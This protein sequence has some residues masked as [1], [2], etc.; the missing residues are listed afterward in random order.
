MPGPSSSSSGQES[1]RCPVCSLRLA[2]DQINGHLDACLAQTSQ[3]S[4]S[5]PADGFDDSDDEALLAATIDLESSLSLPPRQ[6]STIS[7]SDS[8]DD[9]PL[10]KRTRDTGEDS[11]A[12]E[13]LFLDTT[14]QDDLDM[15]AALGDEGQQDESMFACPS[16]Q[17]L[18]VSSDMNNHLDNCLK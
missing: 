1:Q 18:C 10:V 5:G 12:G 4:P 15:L 3:D 17:C 9:E 8:E 7:I 2:P 14:L 11:S 16:C 13:D 6:A